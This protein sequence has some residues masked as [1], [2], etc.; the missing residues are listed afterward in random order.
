MLH[1][2]HTYTMQVVKKSM[3]LTQQ[4]RLSFSIR[5]FEYLPLKH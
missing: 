4:K 3:Q 2:C 1:Q 5:R